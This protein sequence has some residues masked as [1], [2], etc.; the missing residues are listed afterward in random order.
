MC[1]AGAVAPLED[2]ADP[3]PLVL[4]P[5]LQLDQLDV[6]LGEMLLVRRPTFPDLSLP[7]PVLWCDGLFRDVISVLLA[8]ALSESP[9]ASVPRQS[10][11]TEQLG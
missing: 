6:E 1:L 5:F 11:V 7:A 4:D 2:D 8:C 3:E 10:A 9:G